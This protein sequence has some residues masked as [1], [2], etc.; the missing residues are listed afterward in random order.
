MEERSDGILLRPVGGSTPK[1]S[2]ADTAREMAAAAEDWRAWAATDAE[3]LADL[4]WKTSRVSERGS[5][6]ATRKPRSKQ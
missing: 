6:Y 3:G 5:G 2:W 1:L 4:E